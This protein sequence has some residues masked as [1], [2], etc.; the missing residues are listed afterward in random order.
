MNSMIDLIVKQTSVSKQQAQR[1]V[2]LLDTG[3]TVPFIARY[4]KEVTGSLDEVDITAIRD[5]R[6]QIEA[7]FKRKETI[8]STLAEREVLTEKLKMEINA[9]EHISRLEEIYLPFK[10]KRKTR[11]DNAVQAGLTPLADW[12]Q[13]KACA[14]ITLSE[15]RVL[16]KAGEFLS[17]DRGIH[18]TTEAIQGARDILAQRINEMPEVR[19]L[20]KNLFATQGELKASFTKDA[21]S[22]PELPSFKQFEHWHE[23]A[24]AT[25]SHRILALFRAQRL[26]ILNLHIQPDADRAVQRLTR[27]LLPGGS[28]TDKN[29]AA[30]LL[31]QAAQD[32]YKRLLSPSLETLVKTELKQRAD[33]E[34]VHVFSENL[35]QLLLSAPLGQKPVLALDPGLR[36]GCKTVCLNRHGDLLEHT[37][38]YPLAPFKQEKKS[39]EMIVELCRKHHI[40]AIAIGNGTGGRESDAFVRKHVSPFLPEIPVIMVN[41]SGA[42]VYSASHIAREEFPNEDITV[43]GAVSI[44]RR[45]ID[46]LAELVKIDPKSI[47]VGQYQH[48]V[49]QNLLKHALSDVVTSC[50]NAVGVNLNTASAQLLSFVSGL[51][52]RTAREICL[53]RQEH[54]RFGSKTQLFQVQGIGEKSFEQAAGFLRLPDADNPLDRSAVHPESYPVVERIAESLGRPVS[55]LIGDHQLRNSIRI[56]D[57][58]TEATGLPTLND[59]MDE[60]EKPGRDPRSDFTATQFSEQVTD[61]TDLKPGMVIPGVITNVTNF[62]AFVDIGVHKDGLIHISELAAGYVRHPLDVVS[63][64]ERVQ[65]KVL[66]V[67]PERLRIHLSLNISEAQ[68]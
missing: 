7:L 63:L 18:T 61:I 31:Q 8:L 29:A 25:P 21:V 24:A 62:G 68:G 1:V 49:D 50:V 6:T 48:E 66:D 38:I 11:A 15:D 16:Q 56:E 42:S 32:C 52:A 64:N 43:R 55:A 4:R 40:E 54:G 28:E 10:Q 22:H 57:F 47:G 67:E 59:I 45:L 17:E 36:T 51:T 34:A 33:R 44:G 65:V 39:A 60:L 23:P 46:P 37:V 35:R 26:G 5:A 12:I 30:A 53:Y 58:V 20:L 14:R 3:C 9:A 13:E 41:E 27:L 2:E 19:S